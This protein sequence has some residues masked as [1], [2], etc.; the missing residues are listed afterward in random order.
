[1]LDV[2]GIARV[3]GRIIYL[4]VSTYC[5]KCI[6]MKEAGKLGEVISGLNQLKIINRNHKAKARIGI[7]GNS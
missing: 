3:P 6:L 5:M 2:N 7:K 4:M 1:M